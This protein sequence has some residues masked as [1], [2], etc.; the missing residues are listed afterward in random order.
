MNTSA[1]KALLDALSQHQAY[2]YRASS[3]SVNELL[4]QFSSIS[5]AQLL[6]L[7]ELLE[8]LTDAERKALQGLNFASRGRASKRIEEIKA[9]L[10]EWFDSLNVELS[11]DFEKSAIALAVSIKSVSHS[12][13]PTL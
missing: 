1:Q 5:N 13:L 7:S 11:A 12:D 4:K 3:Q 2:L 6:R 10:N 9:I 8:E